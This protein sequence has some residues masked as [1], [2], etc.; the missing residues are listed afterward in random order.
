[1]IWNN[2]ANVSS[3]SLPFNF[4]SPFV[5]GLVN[6]NVSQTSCLDRRRLQ[7]ASILTLLLAFVLVGG[8]QA[9]GGGG[10]K[11]DS[12]AVLP[13]A[14]PQPA[15][16]GVVSGKVADFVKG[17]VVVGATVSDGTVSTKTASD[18]TYS[19]SV[20]PS[21]RKQITVT[22]PG[23]AELQRIVEVRSN[24]TSPLDFSLLNSTQIEILDL[25]SGATLEVPNSSAQVALPANALVDSS[26]KAPAFP[27]KAN[28]TPIDPTYDPRLMPGDYTDTSGGLIESFGALEAHFVD[29]NG[30]KLN[31]ATGKEATIRIPLASLYF[32]APAPT[33]V[34][35]YYYD[36]AQACWVKEGTLTLS[37]SGIDQY[38]EGTVKHFSVW[39]AD[40]A[41]ATTCLKGT[42]Y[43]NDLSTVVSGALVQAV[44]SDY[45]GTTSVLSASDGT[46]TIQVKAGAHITL[47][48]SQGIL[49]SPAPDLAIAT[50]GAGTN[51]T[52]VSQSVKQ[53][54][55][56]VTLNGLIVDGYLNL[57]GRLRD[58]SPSIPYVNA[59]LTPPV[60]VSTSTAFFDPTTPWINPDFEC[61]YG[62]HWGGMVKV[63]LGTDGN[64]VYNN[65]AFTS[66]LIHSK[67]S[68]DAWWHDF[69]SPHGINDAT[70]YEEDYSIPLTPTLTDPN[71]YTYLNDAQFPID[72]KLQGNY[73]YNNPGD[74]NTGGVNNGKSSGHNFHYTYKIHTTFT[75]KK[76][77]Q[78]TFKGDDD[79]WV[80]INK[81]LVI[82]L[83]GVHSSLE[84][85]VSLDTMKTDETT[86]QAVPLI[87][88]QTYDF[89]FFYC[90]RHT[91]ESHM[92]ITTSIP[93]H[94]PAPIPQ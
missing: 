62:S 49:V 75:Y 38:F 14:T 41:T 4:Q 20:D 45:A 21:G 44:G 11:V 89:D 72:G 34:P 5:G 47:K 12:N 77:Q 22:M 35:A 82:D 93:L 31:L 37:G 26:G 68:F 61:R 17:R 36:A 42:I 27:I 83:G 76:G 85:T 92:R 65:P 66:S 24:A 64:P 69:P 56:T 9:C 87:E 51:C 67:A 80:F 2:G 33:T 54:S 32:D 94:N 59:T 46:F 18:G 30:V 57:T 7:G 50:P 90:E 84:K 43:R 79:V 73:I 29:A 60:D 15:A 8:L 58:F 13:T 19:L 28:L 1:M 74:G 78:F 86:P 39:N 81:K 71:T 88:G 91:T 23:Y 55:S 10:G 70:P 53:G 52:T 48:A 16:K 25:S 40:D 6:P 63:D 3:D